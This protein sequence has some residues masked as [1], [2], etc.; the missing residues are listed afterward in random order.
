MEKKRS[1]KSHSIR[2]R[3]T[4]IRVQS[5]ERQLGYGITTLKEIVIIHDYE[6]RR[7]R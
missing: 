6:N 3:G 5:H 1:A 7:N 2:C 4:G